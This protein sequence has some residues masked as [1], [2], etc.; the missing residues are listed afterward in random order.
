MHSLIQ[1]CDTLSNTEL[2]KSIEELRLINDTR[3]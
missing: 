3:S 2:F 1:L